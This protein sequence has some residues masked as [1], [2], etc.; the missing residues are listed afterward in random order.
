MEFIGI[1]LHKNESQVCMLTGEGEILERRI[2]TRA[3]RLVELLGRRPRSRIL[4]ESSTES[5]WVARCLE[6]L[7]HE[8]V[9]ADPN[10]APMYATRSRRVKTDR[11]DAQA[12]LDACRLGAYRAAHRTSDAQRLVRAGLSTRDA[13]VRTRTRLILV[14]RA[15][16]RREGLRVRSGQSSSF[17]RRV[18]ELEV[19]AGL[20]AD[21]DHLLK[22][23]DVVNA[24]VA[25]LDARFADLADRDHVIRRLCSV[26]GV[27]AITAA[28]FVSTLDRVERFRRA[29][30][31]EAYLGLVP[32]ETSSG[33][34]RQRGSV[35]KAGNGRVRWLLVEAAWIV[36]RTRRADTRQLREWA[37][38]IARRRGRRIAALALAR[39]IAG[40]LFALWRDGTTYRA[41]AFDGTT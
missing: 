22:V 41:P 12:L 27:G 35:T 16:L 25:H 18:L 9:V 5:E 13:L 31:V 1:D 26:P 39:R 40:I 3:E 36:L 19:P 30:E 8:V 17:A 7:G 32:S 10:Y 29:H 6:S 20:A 24:E 4:L 23:M 38:G 14:L 11:R 28:A 37:E 34:R 2:A 21:R 15:L 33:E